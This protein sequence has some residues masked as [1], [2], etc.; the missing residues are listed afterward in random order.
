MFLLGLKWCP[1]F[2]SP[3]FQSFLKFNP[4]PTWNLEKAGYWRSQYWRHP[5]NIWTNYDL[6]V[7]PAAVNDILCNITFGEKHQM[8][9]AFDDKQGCFFK[10]T[11]SSSLS[12]CILVCRHKS[13]RNSFVGKRSCVGF[14]KKKKKFVGFCKN[15]VDLPWRGWHLST[16]SGL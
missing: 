16:F 4:C 3:N 12:R 8:W 7:K 10:S 11:V 15:S 9:F 5:F 14:C 1:T 6:L 2:R 13:V